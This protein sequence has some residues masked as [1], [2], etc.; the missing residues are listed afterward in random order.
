[1]NCYKVQKL[2][3]LYSGYDLSKW[4][5]NRVAN[6]LS[7]CKTCESELERIQKAMELTV[8]YVEPKQ[9]ESVRESMW[10]NIQNEIKPYRAIQEQ[11]I[12]SVFVD[13]ALSFV[14]SVL[15]FFR[16]RPLKIKL[17]FAASALVILAAIILFQTQS[18]DKEAKIFAEQKP[19]SPALEQYPT[20]EKVEKPGVTVLTMKTDNP[21]IKVVWFFDENLKL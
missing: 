10:Q 21:R 11:T 13:E 14:S 4:K 15:N 12:Y 16:L 20:V 9:G 6:H 7:S 2:L 18:P 1:M 3:Y 5:M 19:H 8:K 17:G